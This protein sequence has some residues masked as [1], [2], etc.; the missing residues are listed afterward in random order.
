M[1]K[2]LFLSLIVLIGCSN[3]QTTIEEGL[4][5]SSTTL[6]ENIDTTTSS[7]S[8]TTSSTVNENIDEEFLSYFKENKINGYIKLSDDE[9]QK[10]YNLHMKYPTE[11]IWEDFICYIKDRGTTVEALLDEYFPVFYDNE[12]YFN[13]FYKVTDQ[14]LEEYVY[15]F[16]VGYYCKLSND[17]SQYPDYIPLYGRPFYQDGKWWIFGVKEFEPVPVATPGYY[18]DWATRVELIGFENVYDKWVTNAI[19]PEIL[20]DNCTED[21]IKEETYLLTWEIVAGNSDIDYVFIVFEKDGEYYTRAYFEKEY[22]SDSFPFPLANT[23]TKFDQSIDNSEYSGQTTYI[24]SFEVT[25]E[26]NN[27]ARSSCELTFDN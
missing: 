6:V 25:D 23:R 14:D 26:L 16:S 11:F 9:I 24:V 1:K 19:S 5:P 2:F 21:L 18:A 3:Q 8:E 22:H 7:N 27:R 15:R 12:W 20:F 10:T 4:V 17:D 13:E